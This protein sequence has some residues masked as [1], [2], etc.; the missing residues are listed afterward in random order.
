[1]AAVPVGL[2]IIPVAE[3]I[4]P[5]RQSPMRRPLSSLAFVVGT[6]AAMWLGFL[7]LCPL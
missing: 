3:T 1:M 4:N 6:I 7:S 5:F 2:A